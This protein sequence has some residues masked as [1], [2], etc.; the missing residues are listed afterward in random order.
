MEYDVIKEIST[1]FLYL[2]SHWRGNPTHSVGLVIIF[3]DL[4]LVANFQKQCYLIF[5][6]DI[7]GISRQMPAKQ[8]WSDNQEV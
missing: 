2:H 4:N 1:F 3:F 6:E 7:L 5:L 8:F